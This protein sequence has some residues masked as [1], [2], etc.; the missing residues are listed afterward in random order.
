MKRL[1]AFLSAGLIVLFFSCNDSSKEKDEAAAKDTAAAAV[2]TPPPPPPAEAAFTPFKIVMVR[3]KVKDF[4][5]WLP[6]YMGHDSARQ[7]SGVTPYRLGR[8]MEDSNMVLVVDRIS[9]LQKAK[10]FGNSATLKEAMQK[11]GV[12]GKPDV[13]FYEVIRNDSSKIDNPDRLSVTTKVKDFAT[14]LKTYDG[15]GKAKRAEFGLVD[16]AMGR[17]LDDSNTV[18]IVFTVTDMAKA[19][20][21][22]VS[23]ELKKI[24]EEATCEGKPDFFWYKVVQ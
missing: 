14:F 13:A 21:R 9:D 24:M 16:R 3:H 2:P 23:P 10:D 1:S 4:S 17:N 7:A 12:I 5:K 6:V 19:K 11:G 15:E 22:M 18:R 8:S 20:A